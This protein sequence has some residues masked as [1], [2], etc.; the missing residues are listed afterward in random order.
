M[1]LLRQQDGGDEPRQCLE[2]VLLGRVG[3]PLPA[4]QAGGPLARL[5]VVVAAIAAPPF[6]GTDF[7]QADGGRRHD[8]GDQDAPVCDGHAVSVYWYKS[9]MS[10]WGNLRYGRENR[11]DCQLTCRLSATVARRWRRVDAAAVP[12]RRTRRRCAAARP[13]PTPAPAAPRSCGGCWPVPPSW[14]RRPTTAP[15]ARPPPADAA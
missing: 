11:V 8:A 10:L 7:R 4:L 5:A 13:A 12:R 6:G 1:R 14:R 15:A 2:T 9:F 3:A